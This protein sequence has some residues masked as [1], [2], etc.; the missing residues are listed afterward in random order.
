MD[1]SSKSRNYSNWAN[2]MPFAI[3]EVLWKSPRLSID[4]GKPP[5]QVVSM[6][7]P[8]KSACLHWMASFMRCRTPPGNQRWVQEIGVH[9]FYSSFLRKATKQFASTT[10]VLDW[11]HHYKGFL[12]DVSQCLRNGARSLHSGES[13]GISTWIFRMRRSGA[14]QPEILFVLIYATHE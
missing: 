12:C 10:G 11:L 13:R 2:P 1:P 7:V 4:Y 8:T 5:E 3:Q 14:V 6:Y 9:P